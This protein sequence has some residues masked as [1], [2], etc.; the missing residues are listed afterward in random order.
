MQILALSL[1]P[2]LCS[3]REVDN[4]ATTVPIARLFDLLAYVDGS[5]TWDL[6][7]MCIPLAKG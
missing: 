1:R 6:A 3:F 7:A 2:F 4:G 5:R